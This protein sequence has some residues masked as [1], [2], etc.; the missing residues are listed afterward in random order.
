VASGKGLDWKFYSVQ[1]PTN[2]KALTPELNVVPSRF[3]FQR[4]ETRETLFPEVKQE[5]QLLFYFKLAF[6]FIDLGEKP[7]PFRFQ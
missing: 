6:D 5:I 2:S 1:V 7:T 4:L 3:G